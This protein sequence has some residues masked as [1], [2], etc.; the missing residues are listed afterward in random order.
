MVAP[1][2]ILMQF[3][4]L[5]FMASLIHGEPRKG[6]ARN[7]SAIFLYCPPKTLSCCQTADIPTALW[8][9]N[10]DDIAWRN[11]N[12]ISKIN[13]PKYHILKEITFL[14][15]LQGL[16]DRK[17][18]F[19]FAIHIAQFKIQPEDWSKCQSSFY[20]YARE[21]FTLREGIAELENKQLFDLEVTF[22]FIKS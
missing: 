22:T 21:L 7:R 20:G 2:S 18:L 11:Y 5:H 8:L 3:L 17:S 4:L 6:K 10:Q 9:R 16:L 19:K 14:S 1:L 15:V 13:D 12:T